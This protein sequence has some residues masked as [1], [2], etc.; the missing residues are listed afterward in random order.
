MRWIGLLIL[1]GLPAV[2]ASAQSSGGSYV[3]RKVALANGGG[4]PMA[5]GLTVTATVG[6][7]AVALQSGGNYRLTGGFHTPRSSAAP[8]DAL[9]RNGF[10]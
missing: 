1:L 3:L 9:F 8:P 5:A 6:Q 7:S 2:W 10:E 4:R